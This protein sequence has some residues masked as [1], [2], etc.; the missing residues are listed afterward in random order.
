MDPSGL[1]PGLLPL[2]QLSVFTK[3]GHHSDGVTA[4]SADSLHASLE[5]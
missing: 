5:R 4:Q 2:E 3:R 1:F